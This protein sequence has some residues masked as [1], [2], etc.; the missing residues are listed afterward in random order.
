M[1]SSVQ[2]SV[3]AL[4]V[5]PWRNDLFKTA[6]LS[7]VSVNAVR[8]E[9][10]RMDRGSAKQCE[11]GSGSVYAIPFVSKTHINFGYTF[12]IRKQHVF[13]PLQSD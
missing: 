1:D 5:E 2:W 12:L 9:K 3:V 10:R 7:F 4:E 8:L 6:R 13:S 11:G